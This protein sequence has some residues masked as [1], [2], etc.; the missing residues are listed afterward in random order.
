M[1]T[2]TAIPPRITSRWLVGLTCCSPGLN[3]FPQFRQVRMILLLPM[4]PVNILQ[5]RFSAW[6][7]V[8][9]HVGQINS[10]SVSL[11]LSVAGD[12]GVVLGQ[13]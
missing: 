13:V 11:A 12:A 8:D 2:T 7:S 10:P 3:R 6:T 4:K 9:L 5:P 1:I